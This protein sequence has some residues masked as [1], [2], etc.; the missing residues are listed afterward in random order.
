M[1]SAARQ[2]PA[3][4]TAKRKKNRKS[5]VIDPPAANS[6]P[7]TTGGATAAGSEAV[8]APSLV[9][10]SATLVAVVGWEAAASGAGG[11]QSD[12]STGRLRAVVVDM[13]Y[14][15]VQAVHRR[16]FA[17]F[18]GFGVCGTGIRAT[19]ATLGHELPN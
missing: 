10:L 12:V 3:P 4:P 11:V 15:T 19:G 9:A 13:L 2:Y 18:H 1:Q 14:G 7:A 6:S 5:G 16:A 17:S 8:D